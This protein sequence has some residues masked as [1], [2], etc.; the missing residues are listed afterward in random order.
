MSF[1]YFRLKLKIILSLLGKR[2]ITLRKIFNTLYCYVAYCLKLNKS[3][4]TPFLI[5]FDLSNYCNERCIFCRTEDG[6][7]YDQNPTNKCGFLEMGMMNIEIFKDIIQQTKKTLLMAVPY[8]NGEPFI[9]K[10]LGKALKIATDNNVA[11][12]IATNGIL[13]NEE[14]INLALNNGLD[15]IK[16]QVSGYT[17]SAHNIEHRVGSVEAIKE[18]LKLLSKKIKERKSSLIVMI[19]Y[20]L[21]K[22]N[23]HELE[24]FRKFAKDLEF[25]FSVRPGNPLFMEDKEEKQYTKQLPTNVPC[26]WLWKI[27]TINWNGDIFP[28]CDFVTWSDI[29]GYGT[30]V[31]GETNILKI[32]NGTGAMKMREIHK[33]HGRGP[34]LICSKCPRSGVEFKF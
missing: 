20:I 12:M 16:I 18:S 2:K 24:L 13:L 32:W 10:D 17:Q 34:I 33:K 4:V 6:K 1:K 19:D 15:F 14:N 26:D 3:A 9:Y 28:C 7:L 29:K 25:M 22:H 21:Y 27:L 11:T 5:N 8:V 31:P 23:A 30:F